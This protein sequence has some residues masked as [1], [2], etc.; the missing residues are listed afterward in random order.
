MLGRI[1][2]KD[3]DLWLVPGAPDTRDE[4]T[5]LVQRRNATQPASCIFPVINRKT[6]QERV[7]ESLKRCGRAAAGAPLS[8]QREAVLASLG[9]ADQHAALPVDLDDLATAHTLRLPFDPM[10][11]AREV[12]GD[13]R[14]MVRR[15]PP[16]CW[17]DSNVRSQCRS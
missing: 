5:F 12:G 16:G 11:A 4:H 6:S 7:A 3:V 1:A 2:R 14:A 10:A 13:L 17:R 8:T 9:G 15:P